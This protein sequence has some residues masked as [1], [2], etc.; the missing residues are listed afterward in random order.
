MAIGAIW[1]EIWDEAIWD[2]A[3]WSQVAVPPGDTLAITTLTLP[4]GTED[5]A[6]DTT[7]VA[8]GGTAP[9]TFALAVGSDPLPDGL[10]LETTG[11]LHGTPTVAAS[12]TFTVEVT[13]DDSATDT[14]AYTVIISAPAVH[15][16]A[17]TAMSGN[18][19]GGDL[20]ED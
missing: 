2:T 13:D 3:I 4:H 11:Q 19:G 5:V 10:T 9:Y 6:Y 14:Q 20:C 12:F 15:W 18:S 1:A 16:N 7:I 17:L 8:T